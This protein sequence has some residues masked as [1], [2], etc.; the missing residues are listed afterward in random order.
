MRKIFQF[1]L[2]LVVLLIGFQ[3]S[4]VDAN[5]SSGRTI[6]EKKDEW[7]YHNESAADFPGKDWY[8][9]SFDDSSWK[10]GKGIFGYKSSS[11]FDTELSYG[12]DKNQ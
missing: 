11:K 7:K 9:T 6:I 2:A 5:V 10:I 8:T 12:P 3:L 4:P 1:T